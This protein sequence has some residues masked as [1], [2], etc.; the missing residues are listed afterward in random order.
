MYLFVAYYVNMDTDE[1]ISRSIEIESQL[2]D[3]EKRDLR[4][5]YEQSL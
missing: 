4:L 3:T 2:F 1:E 5:C